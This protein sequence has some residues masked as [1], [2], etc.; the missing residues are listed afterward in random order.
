MQHATHVTEMR[1][2]QCFYIQTHSTLITR[3]IYRQSFYVNTRL[4]AFTSPCQENDTRIR[5]FEKFMFSTPLC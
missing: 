3:P 1:S 5:C 4:I 2:I